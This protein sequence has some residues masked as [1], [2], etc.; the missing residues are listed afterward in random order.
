LFISFPGADGA[1]SGSICRVGIGRCANF[2]LVP[3]QINVIR[4]EQWVHSQK[5]SRKD[6]L[7]PAAVVACG[8]RVGGRWKIFPWCRYRKTSP[9]SGL[10]HLESIAPSCQPLPKCYGSFAENEVTA[11]T[12]AG[13]FHHRFWLPDFP[14]DLRGAESPI[15]V[16]KPHSGAGLQSSQ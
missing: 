1:D 10:A 8:S 5:R 2:T 3:S 13:D 6:G 16:E 15:F 9:H 11:D 14:E 12:N 4:F 7:E